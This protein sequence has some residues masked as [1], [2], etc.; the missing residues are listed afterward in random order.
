MNFSNEALDL[1]A[2]TASAN[3]RSTVDDGVGGES[4]H[5]EGVLKED[6]SMTSVVTPSPCAKS[7]RS[8]EVLKN[9]NMELFQKLDYR[10]KVHFNTVP[11]RGYNFM[12]CLQD[13]EEFVDCMTLEVPVINPVKL[14]GHYYSGKMFLKMV[15][16]SPNK[17]F[18]KCPHTRVK[19]PVEMGEYIKDNKTSDRTTM[20]M[21]KDAKLFRYLEKE[22]VEKI[23]TSLL[24][25]GYSLELSTDIVPCDF[26]TKDDESSV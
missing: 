17:K 18:L 15:H 16:K 4:R 24:Y 21:L 1:L 7:D 9:S 2:T 11:V 14:N 25:P 12:T 13:T 19:C 22:R 26:F 23:Q 5:R 20:A 10:E 3:R 6:D 8:D